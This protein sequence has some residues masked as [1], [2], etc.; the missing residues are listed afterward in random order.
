MR[1]GE[2]NF[3]TSD[4]KLGLDFFFL[5]R[6]IT[7]GDAPFFNFISV[8]YCKQTKKKRMHYSSVRVPRLKDNRY[9]FRF[10]QN[11]FL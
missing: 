8:N 3:L 6:N 1:A 9:F 11:I 2:D 7:A 4:L 10:M 5:I